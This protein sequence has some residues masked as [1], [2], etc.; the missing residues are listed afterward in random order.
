MTV[1]ELEAIEIDW[2]QGV[3]ENF[4]RVK[5]AALAALEAANNRVEKL[6]AALEKLQQW[7][8]AYPLDIFPEPNFAD[9]VKALSRAGITLDAVSASN[10]R[11]VLM[12]VK[13]I[14]DAALD[15]E[16]SNDE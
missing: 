5:S 9:A 4:Q 3:G 11:H 6:E 2:T 12:R 10:M 13:E 7:S 16:P 1:E 8:E 14:A 15:K